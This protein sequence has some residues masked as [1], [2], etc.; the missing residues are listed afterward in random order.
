MKRIWSVD[1]KPVGRRRGRRRPRA[2]AGALSLLLVGVAAATVVATSQQASAAD[3]EYISFEPVSGGFAVAGDGKA[4]PLVVDGGDY[5]GV[6]RVVNDLRSDVQKVTGVQPALSNTTP[7]NGEAVLVGTIGKSRLI[8]GLVSGGKL[9]VSTVRGKWETSLQQVVDNPLPGVSKALVIAGSDQRGTIYGVYDMSRRIG[10]SPWWY[11]NDVPARKNSTIYVTPGVHTQGTPAVKYRG[12]F[13]NDE[14]P[15]TGNWARATFGPGLAPCCPAGLTKKYYEKVFETALRLKANYLWPAV[16]GRAFAEDDPDNHATATRYGVVM[17]TSHEAPMMRGIEE[18]NRHPNAYGGNGQ[19]SFVNNSTAVKAYWRDGIKRMEQQGF[20]GVVTLGMRGNGDTSLP[21]GPGIDL[22][23]NII[24]AERQILDEESSK[25]LHQIPQVFTLY[26]EVQ[27]YWD[28]GLRPPDDVTVVFTDDNWG[29]IRK[30]PDR[31]M[32]ARAGG[33]GMYYH[34]DYEGLGRNYQWV[35]TINLANTWEQLHTAYTS[36]IDRLWV[37]NAGDLKNEEAPTQFFLDYAWDPNSVQADGIDDWT[38]R[39]AAQNFGGAAAAAVGDLVYDYGRLQARRKP[40]A[41]NRRYTGST[42]TVTVDD[43]MTP[44]SIENYDELNRVTAD[45]DALLA[46]A[47]QIKAGLPAADQDAY[48]GLVYY[49]IKATANMYHLR[50]AQFLNRL[51][52]AQGR[53]STNDLAATAEARFNDDKAMQTYYNTTLAG[54][55][56]TGWQSQAKFGY[57]DVAKIGNGWNEPAIDAIY[58]AVQRIT[59]PS[60]ASLGVAIDGSLNWWP[61]ASGTPVLPAFS[62]YQTAPA[63]YIDV[64]NRGTTAFTYRVTPSVGWLKATNSSGT[65][66]KQAR[67]VLSVDWSQAPAGTTTVPITVTGAGR[68]VTVQATVIKPTN[69]PAPLTGFVEAGGYVSMDADH[70]TTAVNGNGVS[71]QVVP[72]IGRTE[73]GMRASSVTGPNQTPGGNSPRL[74]YDVNLTKAGAVTLWSYLSPRNNVRPGDGLKYA[75]SIDDQEPKVINATTAT[76]SDDTAMNNGWARNTLDAVNRTSTT[77]TVATP[78]KHTVKFWLVDPTV[79]VQKLILDTGGLRTSY[80]GP[81]E[82]F[83]A[84]G[85]TT[86]SYPPPVGVYN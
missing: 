82:S 22:M 15:S 54:G 85:R 56:W 60:A 4:A 75:I 28:Q 64:F 3:G 2:V 13:I 69:P 12:F 49:A 57:G 72:D 46:R 38:R 68:T 34:F 33:Y 7:T 29:N 8:D 65:V 61:N 58:P 10:V 1:A 26:K 6:V 80:L 35:D 74:E 62:P 53:A 78:G 55:K 63:Q 86:P 50:Q 42:G 73:S 30:V 37:V 71:W 32:P 23:R 18:W 44:F 16:W 41:T 77:F 51:Y 40:E 17:G 24:S 76:G 36:G 20:E 21:D 47:D 83:R 31:S 11:W 66:S 5:A 59:V 43:T 70:Y 19:W 84:D 14:N 9:D 79:V 67:S 81:P 45:W 48:Y 25:P 39:Y 27:R 52:A